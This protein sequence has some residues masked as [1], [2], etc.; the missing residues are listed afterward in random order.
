MENEGPGHLGTLSGETVCTK[1]VSLSRTN[2]GPSRV[3]N[4][5]RRCARAVPAGRGSR[6]RPHYHRYWLTTGTSS[7]VPPTPS[8]SSSSSS[9]SYASPASIYLDLLLLISARA[10]EFPTSPYACALAPP[11]RSAVPTILVHRLYYCSCCPSTSTTKPN[12]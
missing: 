4:G 9:S 5:E 8:S 1:A 3:K 6:H 2:K 11:L 7:S 10:K 12:F